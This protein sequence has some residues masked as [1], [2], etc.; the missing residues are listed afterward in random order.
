MKSSEALVERCVRNPTCQALSGPLRPGIKSFRETIVS[1]TS[2]A[3]RVK[4]KLDH[5]C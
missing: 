4:E 5:S 2:E 3:A 1:N